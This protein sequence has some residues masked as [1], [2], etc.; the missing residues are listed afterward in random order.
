MP[1]IKQS[2][3]LLKQNALLS[4]L[5]EEWEQYDRKTKD[6]NGWIKKS[7]STVESPQYR[8]RP[9]RDQMTYL[10]KTLADITTQKTK[11][12]LNFEKLQVMDFNAR[13]F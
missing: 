4:E 5:T 7:K 11:I 12:T 8:N 1:T 13:A 6:V 2:N 3:S 9:L 10:E